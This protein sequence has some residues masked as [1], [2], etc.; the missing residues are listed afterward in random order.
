MTLQVSFNPVQVLLLIAGD[1]KQHYARPAHA[2]ALGRV[3]G[4]GLQVTTHSGRRWGEN[5]LK[6]E[7]PHWSNRVVELVEAG[8]TT[9]SHVI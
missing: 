1:Y 8:K 5:T 4:T 3:P 6:L 9:V 2:T 7:R